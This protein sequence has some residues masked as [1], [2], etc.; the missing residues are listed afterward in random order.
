M[1]NLFRYL[2]LAIFV[3]S[4]LACTTDDDVTTPVKEES[5][6]PEIPAPEITKI[7]FKTAEESLL[8]G[9]QLVLEVIHT[10]SDLSAPTYSWESSAPTVATITNGR[11]TAI[12]KGEA[13][14]SATINDKDLSAQMKIIVDNI[15]AEAIELNASEITLEVDEMFQL[16]AT[17]SPSNTTVKEITWESSNPNIATVDSTGYVVA[18]DKGEV[19]ITASTSNGI[20]AVSK[21]NVIGIL[22]QE[23]VFNETE[24]SFST[25]AYNILLETSKQLSFDVLPED[26][27]NKEI[28]WSW[29]PGW[30]AGNEMVIKSVDKNGILTLDPRAKDGTYEILTATSASNPE[31]EKDVLIVARDIKYFIKETT[32]TDNLTIKNSRLTGEFTVTYKNTSPESISAGNITIYSTD[33]DIQ[34]PVLE[35]G[36]KMEFT[37]KIDDL[38][39]PFLTFEFTHRG[40]EYRKSIFI[41]I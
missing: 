14:I 24:M 38:F 19:D 6:E 11:V 22:P 15:E 20:K 18:I 30:P 33:I 7:E 41:R 35:P 9:D 40:N 3:F 25:E 32:N 10:P 1:K 8:I 39:E 37:I 21:I 4:F 17:I 13:T 5:P 34:T 16:E 36:Q 31:V 23:I 26:S 28:D 27:E 29:R 12:S 2:F